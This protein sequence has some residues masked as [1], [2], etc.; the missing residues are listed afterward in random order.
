ME[1]ELTTQDIPER[2]IG[3]GISKIEPGIRLRF[4]FEREFAPYIGIEYEAKV[5]DTADIARAASRGSDGLN[6]LIGC[7][8]DFDV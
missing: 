4:E 1:V 3:A 2:G 5:G 8:L 6:V 7:A